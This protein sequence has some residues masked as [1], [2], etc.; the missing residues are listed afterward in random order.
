MSIGQSGV[1]ASPVSAILT[2]GPGEGPACGASLD[3]L[4]A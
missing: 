2:I 3:A 1:P 4:L